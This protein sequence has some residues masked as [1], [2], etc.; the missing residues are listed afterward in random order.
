VEKLI[1]KVSNEIRNFH[2]TVHQ[3][4]GY[5]TE[6]HFKTGCINFQLYIYQRTESE[7][8]MPLGAEEFS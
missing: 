4:A 6:P 8:I 5:E 2:S 7:A 1:E 3:E